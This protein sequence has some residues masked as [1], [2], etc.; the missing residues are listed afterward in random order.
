VRQTYYIPFLFVLI[1]LELTGCDNEMR[2]QEKYK[3]LAESHFFADKMASRPLVEGTVARGALKEDDHLYT[4]KVDGKHTETFPF[5]VDETVLKRG[6]QRYDIYCAVCHD[7]LGYGNG[8]VVQ[9]GFKQ[10]P[11]FHDA[12]LVAAAPGYY[13]DVITHGFGDMNNYAGQIKAYDR[14]AIIAYIRALQLSQNATLAD[15]D[16]VEAEK[17][18]AHKEKDEH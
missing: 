6:Q 17:L 10:P 3:P 5:E 1:I 4:G 9:R 15:A 11:S 12:R 7:R 14:W 13:F 16:P 2:N 8:M 18:L